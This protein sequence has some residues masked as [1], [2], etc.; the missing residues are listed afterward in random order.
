MVNWHRLLISGALI[1]A[2]LMGACMGYAGPVSQEGLEL[3]KFEVKT[4]ANPKIG[5]KVL[6]EFVLRN[7]SDE[8]IQFDSKFGVFVGTRWHSKSGSKTLNRDFGFSYQGWKLWPEQSLSVQVSK[9]LD[10]QGKWSFF[11]TYRVKNRWGP[12]VTE[13]KSLN[14]GMSQAP[15]ASDARFS[16]DAGKS[17]VIY[18]GQQL[19][20]QVFPNNSP[21]NQDI[22]QLPVH[23]QSDTL[24]A[25]V[26]K[27]TSLHPD[28]G[29]GN[30]YVV[31]GYPL[32]K[33]KPYGIPFKVVRSGTKPVPVDIE[34][35]TESDPGPYYIPL[36]APIEAQGKGDAHVVVLHYDQKKLY[37][38]YLAKRAGNAWKAKQGTIWD[39]TTNKLR[40]LGWTSADAAGLPIFPGLVRYEEVYLLKEIRHALRFTVEKSRKAFILPAT[41]YAS[42]VQ[43]PSR[44]PMGMRVRLKAGFDIE[45]FPEPVQV[46]LRCLKKYGMILADN[47]GDF[48]ISGAPHPKW[49]DDALEHL[50]KV[51]G[52]D[53]EVVYTGETITK[54]PKQ[55]INNP[56]KKK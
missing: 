56:R 37:E 29:S 34:W 14:V 30:R 41:H 52:K 15:L 3:I 21:W 8:E 10:M 6:V 40:P 1:C 26:G 25:N 32:K 12:F 45:P 13:S 20:L 11:P 4:P 22:S 39:L 23:P 28:F 18:K 44:P 2:L 9:V 36:D 48:F 17:V 55:M 54:I 24:L 53:L 19:P 35:K 7:N 46:I 43:H 42:S 27:H 16:A 5:D 38:L 51:K 31:F 49:D 33:G 50:K 47:G